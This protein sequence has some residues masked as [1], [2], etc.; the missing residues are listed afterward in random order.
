MTLFI[1]PA[2]GFSN[3]IHVRLGVHPSGNGKSDQLQF[4]KI[5]VTIGFAAGRDNAPFHGADP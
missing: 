5:I 4:W 2:G 1:Y 3:D